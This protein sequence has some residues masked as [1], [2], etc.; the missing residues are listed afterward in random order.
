MHKDHQLHL[1]WIKSV[2]KNN[3]QVQNQIETLFL[4]DERPMLET[5][6]YTIRIGSTTTFLYFNLIKN[7]LFQV[8]MSHPA[9]FTVDRGCHNSA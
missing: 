7:R 2:I 8:V 6:D 3:K 4:S 9:L 1:Q 5:L